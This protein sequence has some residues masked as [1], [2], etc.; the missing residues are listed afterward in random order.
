LRKQFTLTSLV[1]TA[2]LAT[3]ALASADENKAGT[4]SVTGVGIINAAPD[5][6]TINLTVLREAETA[7]SALSDNN[8]AM[9]DILNAMKEF[10]VEDK[11]LQTSNFSVQPR[12]IY[13][14]NTNQ[15]KSPRI[16][17]YQVSNSLAIRIRDLA[18][19]GEILDKSVTLG[20]NEGGNISFGNSDPKPLQM[21]ARAE[22][23]KSAIEKAKV[24]TEAAGVEI[25]SSRQ[26]S[27]QSFNPSPQPMLRGQV[28]KMA[29]AESDAVPI[30]SGEN[31]YRITV[32]VTFELDQ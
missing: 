27:E 23:M 24:L 6:A 2:M 14:N 30:A 13:P 17:A 20:V 16:V 8:S 15:I 4:I 3:T 31:T 19:V 32:N 21:Q 1:I 5:M 18:R 25:G 11:D 29:M 28:A 10:G 7:K 9:N 22:A 26:I 12:Y